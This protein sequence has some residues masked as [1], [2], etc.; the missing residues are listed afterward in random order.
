LIGKPPALAE[1]SPGSTVC[2]EAVV[3]A[4]DEFPSPSPRPSPQGRGGKTRR[5]DVL[6][7][8]C[9]LK[10]RQ[11]WLPLPEREGWGEGEG[12]NP[13]P[14]AWFAPVVCFPPKGPSGF[15]APVFVMPPALSEV[16][17]W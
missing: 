8:L 17:D 2:A 11:E 7:A 3:L 1:D 15:Q 14:S 9:H 13:M 5:V 4:I 6:E 10:G 16:A 12:D